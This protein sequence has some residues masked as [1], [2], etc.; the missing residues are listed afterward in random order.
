M[1]W[2]HPAGGVCL[3]GVTVCVPLEESMEQKGQ[4]LGL[5]SGLSLGV[6]GQPLALLVLRQVDP[7]L[8]L[9]SVL[10]DASYEGQINE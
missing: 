2:R 7:P 4:D 3:G 8:G 9:L 1:L 10:G 5:G 6:G